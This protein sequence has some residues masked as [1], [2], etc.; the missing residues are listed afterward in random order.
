M[1]VERTFLAVL[2]SAYFEDGKRV[3]LKLKPTLA[4]IKVAVFPLV[5]NKTK[6]VNK[7]RSL[8]DKLRVS[9]P[10]T[11][12]DRGN[13]GKRYFSQD[14]IGTPWCLTIDYQTLED[15]TVTIRDRDTTRQER[16]NLAKIEEYL[17]AHV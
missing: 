8:F 7:A 1:G 17:S 3:V 13:I 11:W 4:P 14:E 10:S 5:H 9:V 12:D 6:L 16:I 2:C 15:D